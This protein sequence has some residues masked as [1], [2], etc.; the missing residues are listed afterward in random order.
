MVQR[1]AAEAASKPAR[2]A[3]LHRR[4]QLH[5]GEPF[6]R[7]RGSQRTRLIW[8]QEKPGATPG[9][10]TIFITIARSLREMSSALK[11]RR[12]WCNSSSGG[13][14]VTGA[15]TFS[16]PLSIGRAMAHGRR[17]GD[18]GGLQVRAPFGQLISHHSRYWCNSKHVWL[19]PRERQG[20]TGIPHHFLNRE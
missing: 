15:R 16:P 8:D 4:S 18:R 3:I 2:S 14:F 9:C 13:H 7:T 11:T 19:P 20:G 6:F 10:P 17:E 12:G 5:V 1:S